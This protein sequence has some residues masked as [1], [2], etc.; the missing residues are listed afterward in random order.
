MEINQIFDWNYSFLVQQFDPNS[1]TQKILNGSSYVI[2]IKYILGLPLNHS[3]SIKLSKNA[4]DGIV[5]VWKT[6]V[7]L[8]GKG[9]ISVKHL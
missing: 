4:H 6:L 8:K 7:G 1:R 5:S 3:K 9:E 2:D